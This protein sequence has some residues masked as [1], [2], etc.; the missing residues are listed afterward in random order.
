M[1]AMG[2]MGTMGGASSPLCWLFAHIVR[3][4]AWLLARIVRP[5]A[6]LIRQ[7]GDGAVVLHPD[8]AQG[9]DQQRQG[10]AFVA[11]QLQGDD[12]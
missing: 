8:Q 3:S 7:G 9:A 5:Y 2:V 12:A 1:C 10:A 4:Y 6:W 11:V